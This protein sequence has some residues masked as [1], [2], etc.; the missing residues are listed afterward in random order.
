M[1][2]TI[3]APR[4]AALP[5]FFTL[6]ALLLACGGSSTEVGT[7]GSESAADASAPSRDEASACLALGGAGCLSTC[8]GDY[9]VL[10]TTA[11]G[12]HGFCCGTTSSG[13]A[14]DPVLDAGA[15]DAGGDASKRIGEGCA[16]PTLLCFGSDATKCCG[17]DP[18]GSAV[19]VGG[20]WMCGNAPAPGCNGTSCMAS[21][22]S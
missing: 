6:A 5:S 18:A 14:T 11:C 4:G 8:S 16:G 1:S 17:K 20:S 12:N 7:S 21:G 15:A 22:G 9:V 19:C 3:T 10:S 2:T 13:A